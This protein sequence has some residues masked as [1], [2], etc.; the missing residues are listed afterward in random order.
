MNLEWG[1]YKKKLRNFM[2]ICSTF[3]SQISN[4]RSSAN[5]YGISGPVYNP[6]SILFNENQFE[7]NYDENIKEQRVAG[8]SSGGSAAA[9]ATGMCFA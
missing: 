7:K 9:V 8:G 2:I 6:Q 4:L 3:K 1:K 5:I